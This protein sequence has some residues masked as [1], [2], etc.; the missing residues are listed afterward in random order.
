[1]IT[2]FQK[3]YDGESLYD[4]DRDVSEALL[5]EYNP[6]VKQEEKFVDAYKHVSDLDTYLIKLYT[7]L[8]TSGTCSK[9]VIQ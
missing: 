3:D 2:I 7:N 4:L 5:E 9:V 1:M 8:L 6:V